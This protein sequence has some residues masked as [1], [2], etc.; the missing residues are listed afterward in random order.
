MWIEALHRIS[1]TKVSAMMGLVPMMTLFFAY[2]YLDEVPQLRQILG[3]IPVLIVGYLLT[4][5]IKDPNT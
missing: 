5:P 1:I 3:I 4:K 2:L